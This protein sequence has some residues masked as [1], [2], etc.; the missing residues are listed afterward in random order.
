MEMP[1]TAMTLKLNRSH[2]LDEMNL[3][4]KG[5]KNETPQCFVPYSEAPMVCLLRALFGPVSERQRDSQ[6]LKQSPSVT[7]ISYAS[8]AAGRGGSNATV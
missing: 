4:I 7:H 2:P 3:S 8:A 6:R 5:A 1:V